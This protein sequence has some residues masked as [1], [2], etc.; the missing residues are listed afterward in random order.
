M[1]TRAVRRQLTGDA[2]T[3]PVDTSAHPTG[4]WDEAGRM[5]SPGFEA[6]KGPMLV[7]VA[8]LGDRPGSLALLSKAVTTLSASH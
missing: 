4:P 5:A 8:A 2:A 7:Q 3:E 1:G 6:V